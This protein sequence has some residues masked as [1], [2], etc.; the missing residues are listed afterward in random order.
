L[1]GFFLAAMTFAIAHLKKKESEVAG[2]FVACAVVFSALFVGWCARGVFRDEAMI[3]ESLRLVNGADDFR[4]K[5]GRFAHSAHTL[6]PTD[7]EERLIAWIAGDSVRYG[8]YA[9]RYCVVRGGGIV[10]EVFWSNER[11]WK[12]EKI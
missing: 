3:A 8:G 9:D 6:A 2:S 10:G 12:V 5:E 1:V 7:V 4:K 11:K